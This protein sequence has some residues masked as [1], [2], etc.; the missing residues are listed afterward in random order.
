M[1]L[2]DWP[3]AVVEAERAP[4]AAPAWSRTSSTW[5]ATSTCFY[6]HCRVYDA[7]DDV[8]PFRVEV[9]RAARGVIALG[10]DLLGV[11]APQR[12]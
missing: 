2:A 11:E 9:T 3:V 4:R 7:P 12:M 10:L 6:E 5:R 1:R 8:K